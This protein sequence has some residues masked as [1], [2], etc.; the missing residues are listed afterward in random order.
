MPPVPGDAGVTHYEASVLGQSVTVPVSQKTIVLQVPASPANSV[1]VSVRF[2]RGSEAG[3]WMVQKVDPLA[4]LGPDPEPLPQPAAFST[5]WKP[6]LPAKTAT[7]RLDQVAKTDLQQ[8]KHSKTEAEENSQQP[9]ATK[10]APFVATE[11]AKPVASP[12][13]SSV[14]ATPPVDP[15]KRRVITGKDLKLVGGWRVPQTHR[16]ELRLTMAFTNGGLAVDG[17]RILATH[18]TGVQEFT[19]PK[20]GLG[21]NYNAWPELTPARYYP[22]IY[23]PA[24]EANAAYAAPIPY[25]LYLDN[26]SP[27][28]SGKLLV[29]GRAPYA[30]PPP[31]AGYITREGEEAAYMPGGSTAQKHGGGICAIPA[32]FADKYLGGKRLAIGYGGSTSGQGYTAGPSLI[33]AASIDDPKPI[34][35]IGFGT[36]NTQNPALR[37]RRFP[38]YQKEI[39]WVLPPDGDVGYWA[40][41]KVRAG[42]CW[43]D[44]PTHQGVLY[45]STQG[46]GVLSYGPQGEAGGDNLSNRQRMYVYSPNDL[47]EVASGKRQP[48]EMRAKFY[49]WA[50]CTPIP[51][52]PTNG[53]TMQGEV[54]GACWHADRLY[55]LH[56]WIARG[57]VESYPI[58]AVYEIAE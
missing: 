40:L 38:D 27:G 12:P 42:P 56:R 3:P 30:S 46:T 39:E 13:K 29:T 22:N 55:L 8:Q 43:V 41:D 47:A 49:E 35:L 32:P 51:S 17:S 11:E 4:E 15:T 24:R 18:N 1:E 45:W 19:A 58:V 33:A 9:V 25:G 34:D 14:R 36:F 5:K 28:S 50:D 16:P 20:M 31:L 37:E 52:A 6:D 2:R 48:N 44:T 54:V 10:V 57:D 7:L 26:V 21:D 23:T 53:T